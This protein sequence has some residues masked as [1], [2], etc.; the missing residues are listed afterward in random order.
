[1]TMNNLPRPLFP[2][3]SRAV[4]VIVLVL[5]SALFLGRGVLRSANHG[6]RDFASPY[7]GARLLATGQNPYADAA[8]SA[9]LIQ[10]GDANG[11]H[12]TSV[13]PPTTFIGLAMFTPF[14]VTVSKLLLMS[15]SI[16][17]LAAGIHAWARRLGLS[18]P[19]SLASIALILAS[20]PVTTG[21]MV[22]NPAL[23]AAG[24][25]FLGAALQKSGRRYIAFAL[26]F[27]AVLIKPQVG[28]VGIAWLVL[29]G[30]VRT[31]LVLGAV[32]FFS[33]IGSLAWLH[34]TAP[35]ALDVWRANMRMEADSGSVL[36]TGSLGMQRI[37]PDGLWAALTHTPLSPIIQASFAMIFFGVA[38]FFI[39][40]TQRDEY[41]SVHILSALGI[42]S[43]LV[44]YHR[45]HDA[46]VLAP[47]VLLVATLK[48]RRPI[49]FYTSAFCC[50][51]W[52]LPG[53]GFWWKAAE[54]LSAHGLDL[55]SS[56]LWTAGLM[57]VHCWALLLVA[58]SLL[59]FYRCSQ[60]AP[61]APEVPFQKN[62]N[63]L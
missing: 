44:C 2:R 26:M 49:L 11:E 23:L 62:A 45:G 24:A 4:L 21:M 51:L 16:A 50:L 28:A 14:S 54:K 1:M 25:L 3:E 7:A 17:L 39:V 48:Q 18:A 60:S 37:D 46:V 19:A 29:D 9:E 15:A 6:L 8:I 63:T 47:F 34:F 53:G 31:G 52:I 30:H 27:W 59:L 40:R 38:L 33:G 10:G 58:G 57:R 12:P 22:I 35:G 56:P 36:S 5:A 13:Y 43:L 41:R 42:A 32:S 20:A 61:A 55:L